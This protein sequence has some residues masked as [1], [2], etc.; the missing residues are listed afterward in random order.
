VHTY[1]TGNTRFITDLSL[2]KSL[3]SR[4][5]LVPG[6]QRDLLDHP[7]GLPVTPS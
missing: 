7:G 3:R 1:E 4:D 6:H 2:Q 5:R